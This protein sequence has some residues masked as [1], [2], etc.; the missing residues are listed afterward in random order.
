MNIFDVFNG[1][2][3]RLHVYDNVDAPQF[4]ISQ[5]Y[6]I[7]PALGVW[8][9]FKTDASGNLTII[10]TGDKVGIGL[11]ATA[12]QQTLDVFRTARIRS[13]SVNNLQSEIVVRNPANGDLF[14]NTSI[15]SNANNAWYI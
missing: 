7:D 14:L 13:M 6:N 9:D 4:R 2:Q 1:P 5:T 10:P 15:A 11:L 8:A 12:P 3:R